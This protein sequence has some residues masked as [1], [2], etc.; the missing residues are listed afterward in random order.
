ME[1]R[2]SLHA[3]WPALASMWALSLLGGLPSTGLPSRFEVPSVLGQPP[4]AE[5]LDAGTEGASDTLVATIRRVEQVAPSIE[6]ITGISLVLRIV[7]IDVPRACEIVVSGRETRME[8]LQRGYVV[9]IIY[10][11]EAGRRVAERI[12]EITPELA[13]ESGG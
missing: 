6:V 3:V 4:A 9:R 2:F 1:R 13:G 12:E 7:S 8:E 5:R 10:Y 11:R